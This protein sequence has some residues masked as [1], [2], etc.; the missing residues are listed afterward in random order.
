MN[1][2]K[3]NH[4]SR[5]IKK[6]IYSFIKETF[7]FI[8]KKSYDPIFI[9]EK[10]ICIYLIKIFI[11][12]INMVKNIYLTNLERKFELITLFRKKDFFFINLKLLKKNRQSYLKINE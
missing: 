1:S 5:C 4:I 3:K 11:K 2:K 6:K 8:F 12:K 7:N 9:Y 10:I